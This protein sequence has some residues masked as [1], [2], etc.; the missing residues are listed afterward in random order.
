MVLFEYYD[1]VPFG[2]GYGTLVASVELRAKGGMT[3]TG[4]IMT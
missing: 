1:L 4:H 3:S 2:S